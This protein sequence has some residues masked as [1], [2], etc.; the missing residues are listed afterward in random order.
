MKTN[1]REQKVIRDGEVAV[2][3]SPGYGAGWYSWNTE[4]KQL[5]FHPKLVEMVEQKRQKEINEE[6]VKENLGIDIYA[7]GADGLTICWLPIGT[8]FEVDEYD[9]SESLRTLSDLVIVA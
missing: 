7:G 3:I 4:H 1:E 8:A 6:W 5:L 2:L 9:G